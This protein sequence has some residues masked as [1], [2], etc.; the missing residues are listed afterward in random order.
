LRE[1][2]SAIAAIAAV[3][4]VALNKVPRIKNDTFGTKAMAWLR[5]SLHLAMELPKQQTP[6]SL[7]NSLLSTLSN[8]V[9]LSSSAK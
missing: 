4:A 1:S 8:S 5:N 3:A 6:A 7:Y 9:A 2:Q